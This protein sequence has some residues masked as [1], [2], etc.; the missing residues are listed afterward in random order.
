MELAF[1]LV[2]AVVVAVAAEVSLEVPSRVNC[3]TRNAA[4]GEKL[5]GIPAEGAAQW[6]GA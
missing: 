4:C 5:S 2:V 6:T 1:G 3:R